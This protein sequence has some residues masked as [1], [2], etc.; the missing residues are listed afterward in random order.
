MGEQKGWPMNGLLTDE[1]D[2]VNVARVLDQERWTLA[3]RRTAQLIEC[4]QP[5]QPSNEKRNAVTNYVTRL[6]MNCFPCR[7]CTFGSVPLKTYLPDGDIDL[8]ALTGDN[9]AKEIWANKVRHALECEERNGNAEFRVKEVQFIQAEVKIIKCLVENIVVD[10]SFN[11]VGGLCTL[12]FLEEVG[13]FISHSHLFKRSIILIKAWCYYESRILGAHHGLISTYALETLVLYIF[14][15]YNNKFAGPLE[16]LYRFLEFFSNF[17]WENYCISL[18]GPVPINSLP[19]MIAEPPRRDDEELLLNKPFLEWCTQNYAVSPGGQDGQIF[20][21]KFFNVIDPL[22]TSNNLGRS[23]GKGN[24]FR[25]RS[26]FTF[27]AKRLVSLLECRKDEIIPELNQFFK[28]TWERHGTGVRPD[29]PLPSLQRKFPNQ[30]IPNMQPGVG[31]PFIKGNNNNNRNRDQK[32]LKT[33]HSLSTNNGLTKLQFARTRSSP[34][35]TNASTDSF[36][37]G[38]QGRAVDHGQ[39]TESENGMGRR[40][41]NQLGSDVSSNHSSK[42]LLD[43]IPRSFNNNSDTNSV[44]SSSYDNGFAASTSGEIPS[45]EMSQEEQDMINRMAMHGFNGQ[46]QLPA[47]PQNLPL[48]FHSLFSSDLNNLANLSLIGRP[49]SPSLQFPPGFV[50]PPVTPNPYSQSSVLD[51][52]VGKERNNTVIPNNPDER[53]Q[54]VHDNYVVEPGEERYNTWRDNDP[55]AASRQSNRN[56]ENSSSGPNFV[57]VSV[58]PSS[59]LPIQTRFGRGDL[60]PVVREDIIAHEQRRNQNI[61]GWTDTSS[62]DARSSSSRHSRGSSRPA[63]ENSR[64]NNRMADKFPRS[65]RE[66]WARKPAFPVP[67]SHSEKHK[68]PVWQS[69]S[70]AEDSFSEFDNDSADWASTSAGDESVALE[71]LPHMVYDPALNATGSNQN[72]VFPIGGP[73]LIGPQGQR[74]MDNSGRVFIPTGPPIPFYFI[75]PT[76]EMANINAR[77]ASQSGRDETLSSRI[78]NR[79]FDSV[80]TPDLVHITPSPST[81]S[82]VID[83][84]ERNKSDIFN[85][86]LDSHLDNLMYG[87]LCLNSP[88]NNNN[89]NNN[90]APFIAQQPI[91][92]P[93]Q[94]F[95]QGHFP[96]EGQSRPVLGNLNLTQFSG[97]GGPRLVPLMP[98]QPGSERVQ[99]VSVTPRFTEEPPRSR[100]GTGTYLPNPKGPYRERQSNARNQRWNNNHNNDNTEREGSWINAKQR[101]ALNRRGNSR[102]ERNRNHHHHPTAENQSEGQ[103]QTYRNES[104]RHEDN[105]NKNNNNNNTSSSNYHHHRAGPKLSAVARGQGNMGYNMYHLGPPSVPNGVV[106]VGSVSQSPVVM[107]YSYDQQHNAGHGRNNPSEIGS[108]RQ[109]VVPVLDEV[110]LPHELRRGELSTSS[111]EPPS[112]AHLNRSEF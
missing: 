95:L 58:I 32:S 89:N 4:I 14:H 108:V 3:E 43:E 26:A 60:L 25:I 5:N 101:A 24:F 29:C 31:D 106:H 104:Y 84:D 19:N 44:V 78:S 67:V 33:N 54:L 37:R 51:Q 49:W 62:S 71:R 18:W 15:I 42:S 92:L 63:Y 45:M 61:T 47:G 36:P 9:D 79:D 46:F 48:A 38:R 57:P 8:T 17:D 39:H 73:V 11:Q 110:I 53:M 74:V 85:S 27:G 55:S 70:A 99:S 112:P 91:M 66:K 50:S 72:P 94:M 35:L 87:R 96:S 64:N 52:M 77:P 6:I 34:E 56:R 111:P 20:S 10:I 22:R 98:F 7:V 28:N 16:V 76:R 59:L 2:S 75:P 90:N 69:E 41:N 86:D 105:I 23:V 80:F 40:N 83:S 82:S 107:V 103:W 13:R 81:A 68:P 109:S 97:Y 100:V 12:C 88:Y 65:P 1:S 93:P 102:S 30:K 21:S